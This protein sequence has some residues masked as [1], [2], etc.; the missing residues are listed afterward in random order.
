MPDFLA[1]PMAGTGRLEKYP[2]VITPVGDKAA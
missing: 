1:G 2:A